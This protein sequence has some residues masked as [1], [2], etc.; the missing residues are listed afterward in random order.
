MQLEIK[1]L[2]EPKTE[3]AG[4]ICREDLNELITVFVQQKPTLERGMFDS[5]FVPEELSRSAWARSSKKPI[6]QKS[7]RRK[8][9]GDRCG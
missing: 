2:A 1:G 3:E 6:P 4:R 5:E 8:N 7:P 9:S